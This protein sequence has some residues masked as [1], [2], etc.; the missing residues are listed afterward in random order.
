MRKQNST[1]KTAFTSEVDKN[2]KN[3]DSFG[4]VELDK[5]ACYVVADGIDDQID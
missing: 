2:L 4:F 1:F 5:F 3:T